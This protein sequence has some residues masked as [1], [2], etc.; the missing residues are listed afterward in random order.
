MRNLTMAKKYSDE[1]K[2]ETNWINLY[3]FA[4]SEFSIFLGN[5]SHSTHVLVVG[6]CS[7]T[8][9]DHRWMIAL[10]AWEL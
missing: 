4:F 5:I 2:K 6:R 10:S 3:F 8:I 7:E 1:E 9:L